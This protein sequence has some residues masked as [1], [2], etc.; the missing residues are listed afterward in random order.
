METSFK[1]DHCTL[2]TDSVKGAAKATKM[3]QLDLERLMALASHPDTVSISIAGIVQQTD[4]Q[5]QYINANA[6]YVGSEIGGDS[7][8]MGW[9]HTVSDTV[10]NAFNNIAD[11]LI[12]TITR[13]DN[14]TDFALGNS[15]WRMHELALEDC[16]CEPEPQDEEEE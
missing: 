5:M 13:T 11:Q 7:F 9:C 2:E 6:T 3:V 16:M 15:E 1:V 8:Q 4:N 12:P 14:L 10:R